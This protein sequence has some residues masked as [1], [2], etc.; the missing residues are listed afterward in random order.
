MTKNVYSTWDI[1]WLF[2]CWV[3]KGLSIYPTKNMVLN[4]GFDS[5]ATHTIEKKN[6]LNK[7]YLQKMGKLKHPV[8][9]KRNMCA[10]KLT[11]EKWFKPRIRKYILLCLKYFQH[12]F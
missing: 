5:A 9:I 4:I 2:S 11:F 7:I 6:F 1:Q 12:L 3:N 10:D 8:E